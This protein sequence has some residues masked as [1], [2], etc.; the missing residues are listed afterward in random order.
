MKASRFD[1]LKKIHLLR[2]LASLGNLNKTAQVHRVTASAISQSIKALEVSLGYTVISRQD[3]IW[4]LTEKGSELLLQ[5]EKI[6]TAL[7]ETFINDDI[8]N[9]EMGSLAIGTYESIALELA[10]LFCQEIRK[11]FPDIRLSIQT[12][13]TSELLKKIQSG[14]LCLAIVTQT[15]KLPLDFLREVIFTDELALYRS[16]DSSIRTLKDIKNILY[17]VIEPGFDGHPAYVK[18]F[19][20]Q[21]DSAKP[22]LI[23]DSFE[24]LKSIAETGNAVVLLPKK[25]AQKSSQNLVELEIPD[26]LH[27]GLHEILLVASKTC[28]LRE[29]KYISQLLRKQY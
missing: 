2:T 10:Q 20:K 23:C 18:D 9:F 28:D 1:D 27:S 15:D 29:F 3:E 19:L 17:G 14:E 22:N 26:Q 24:V 5:T 4:K 21:I 8:E 13:R 11:D 16:L 12:D 25:V 7:N 6:F